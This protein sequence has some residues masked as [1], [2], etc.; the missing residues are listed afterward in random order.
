M[1]MIPWPNG[2]PE[3][4]QIKGIVAYINKYIHV[5]C[6]V[7]SIEDKQKPDQM[8]LGNND[9]LKRKK[10]PYTEKRAIFYYNDK[11]CVGA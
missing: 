4:K 10:L 7:R 8:T 11:K 9:K 3:W 5:T 6:W 1:W 2:T